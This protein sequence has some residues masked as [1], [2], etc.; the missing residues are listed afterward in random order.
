MNV[1]HVLLVPITLLPYR[2]TSLS[3]YFLLQEGSTKR[4]ESPVRLTKGDPEPHPEI[5]PPYENCTA[6]V[7]RDPVFG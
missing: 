6:H 5:L 7:N 3:P 4:P 1:S 2:P